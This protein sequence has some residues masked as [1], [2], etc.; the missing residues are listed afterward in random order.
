MNIFVASSSRETKN[1]IYNEAAEKIGNFIVKGKHNYVF[2]GCKFGL[3]KKIYS[4]VNEGKDSKIIIA[5]A[6]AYKEELEDI[7]FDE[8]TLFDNVNE[9]KNGLIDVSDILIFITGGIG[10]LD[11]LF[12]AIEMKRSK[13]HDKPIIIV[14]VDNYFECLIEMLEKIYK[15]GFADN[16]N[17]KLYYIANTI[18]EAIEKIEEFI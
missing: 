10:T 9:R 13:V 14:N 6:E 17:R 4:I 18:E 1:E 16:E 15:E 12:T 5:M 11:E 2:G 8:V 3:M 7:N